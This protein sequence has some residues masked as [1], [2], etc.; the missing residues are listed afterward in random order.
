LPIDRRIGVAQVEVGYTEAQARHEASRCL[1]CWENTIFEPKGENTGTECILCGGC[2]DVCPENCI[3]LVT[4]GRIEADKTLA[5]QLE[6][7]YA[8]AFEDETETTVGAVMIKDEDMCI[9]CGLCAL[10]CPVGCIT[11]EGY[12][13]SETM[14]V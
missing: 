13:V 7:E 8:I 10:R 12:Y 2:V 1:H 11:M 3:E 14:A 9:R 6:E 4:L 5:S